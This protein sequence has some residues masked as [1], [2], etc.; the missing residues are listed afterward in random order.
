[1]EEWSFVQAGSGAISKPCLE[2]SGTPY[3]RC[4]F[5]NPGN[6][7]KHTRDPRLQTGLDFSVV[8]GSLGAWAGLYRRVCRDVPGLSG[9]AYAFP[10]QVIPVGR[11]QHRTN[12]ATPQKQG[13]RPLL[14]FGG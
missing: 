10:A 1:M 9:R 3:F 12:T 11:M 13:H 4:T 14:L 6:F 8:G 2:L 7:P 5:L